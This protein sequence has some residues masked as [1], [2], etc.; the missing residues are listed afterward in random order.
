MATHKHKSSFPEIPLHAKWRPERRDIVHW[1]S[2][3]FLAMKVMTHPRKDGNECRGYSA[4]ASPGQSQMI[5]MVTWGSDPHSGHYAQA[6]GFSH[7]G[8]ETHCW[9]SSSYGFFPMQGRLHPLET[10]WFSFLDPAVFRDRLLRFT[11]SKA[12]STTKTVG[13][14][15]VGWLKKFQKACLLRNI[16]QISLLRCLC[17]ISSKI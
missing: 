4:S 3:Y 10:P 2:L 13:F 5:G 12:R 11:R 16:S 14:P 8:R 1:A 15:K 6:L 17:H 9:L 7:Q